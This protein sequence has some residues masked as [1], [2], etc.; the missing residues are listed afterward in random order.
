MKS[1]VIVILLCSV[2]NAHAYIVTTLGGSS[3]KTHVFVIGRA[4]NLGDLF[5]RSAQTKIMRYKDMY[6]NE[7]I[8]VIGAGELHKK[9]SFIKNNFGH[10][11][12]YSDSKKLT[13][14]RLTS[15][16]KKL[17]D[18][19]SVDFFS[20]SG[21]VYGIGIERNTPIRFSNTALM[22]AIK[23]S[24]SLGAYV[25]INGCNSGFV[26]AP[27]MSEVLGVPVFGSLTSTDFQKIHNNGQW[28]I[29]NRGFYPEGGFARVN[30]SS[31]A[32]A[33]NCYGQSGCV[34]MKPDNHMYVGTWGSY[35]VGLPYYRPFCSE[36]VSQRHCDRSIAQEVILYPAN[37]VASRSISR[38]EFR[39]S[40]VDYICPQD[41]N[42]IRNLSCKN[43]LLSNGQ[44]PPTTKIFRGKQLECTDS[45]CHYKT[46]GSG[47]RVRF[48][49]E[50]I[51]TKGY[52]QLV[53]DYRRFM[54][55]FPALR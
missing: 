25:V 9:R 16:F 23:A 13:V 52:D 53:V 8:L 3:P 41:K 32:T 51:Y 30:S 6:P 27:K 18:V 10:K 19:Q 17:D 31:Y 1:S 43:Y 15:L 48:E 29:N 21:A 5:L 33:K 35:K 50:Q 37:R 20:H 7:R 28:Y 12:L 4:I 2:L 42:S 46:S 36:G 47:N 39:D 26:Q 22:M 38:E 24:F 54:Q 14:S 11:I 49:F 55:S 34:R 40:V 45:R 44:V